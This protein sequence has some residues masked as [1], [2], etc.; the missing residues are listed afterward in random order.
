M[1][2][3]EGATAP[4]NGTDDGE[5]EVAALLDALAEAT[6]TDAERELVRETVET[7]LG[8]EV[9]P[10]GQV[11]VGFDR[12]DLAEALL[13][14]VVFGFLMLVEGGTTEVGA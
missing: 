12:S 7:D 4:A 13:G 6:D 9:G 2:G 10:F 1:S 8:I 14:S 11:V 3:D 5:S